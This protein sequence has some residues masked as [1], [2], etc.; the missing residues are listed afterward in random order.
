MKRTTIVSLCI[1]LLL[2]ACGGGQSKNVADLQKANDDLTQ[3][4]KTLE[5]DL[6]E[7]DKKLIQHQQAMQLLNERLRDIEGKIQKIELS[8]AR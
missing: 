5:N 4:V 8:P 2:S 7:A 1:L 3:R 6:L